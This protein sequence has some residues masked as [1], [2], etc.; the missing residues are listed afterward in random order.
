MEIYK[1]DC[2]YQIL[3]KG[4][5]ILNFKYIFICS[6][7]YSFFQTIFSRIGQLRKC[8]IHW[9]LLGNSKGTADVEYVNAEDAAK[10]IKDY[11]GNTLLI[12][13]NSIS[14]RCLN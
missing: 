14:F 7:K 1:K 3:T 12:Y 13:F 9:D 6:N 10:A 5:L 2:L 8:G 11:N 4:W